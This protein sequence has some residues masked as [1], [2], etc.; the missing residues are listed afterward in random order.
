VEKG[1]RN[2]LVD[3]RGSQEPAR[4]REEKR[5]GTNPFDGFFDELEEVDSG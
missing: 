1:S 3:R 5:K 2:E 4:D